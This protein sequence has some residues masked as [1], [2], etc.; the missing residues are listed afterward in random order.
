M[1]EMAGC[2]RLKLASKMPLTSKYPLLPWGCGVRVVKTHFE[3][4]SANHFLCVYIY[5]FI[6]TITDI[7]NWDAR[8]TF[9]EFLKE[10]KNNIYTYRVG[11][12]L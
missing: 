4:R 5:T 10:V 8:M 1:G 11:K 3:P 2:E 12:I 9:M 7:I 6:Y